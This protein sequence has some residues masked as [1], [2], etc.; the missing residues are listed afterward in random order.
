VHA[1]EPHYE[2][3]SEKSALIQRGQILLLDMWAK[4]KTENA[5]YGDITWMAYTGKASDIPGR[6]GE[7]FHIL[8]VARDK[9]ISFLRENIERQ[10]VYG[11]QVDDAC[12]AVVKDGGFGDKFTH[13]TGHSITSSVHGPGPNIDNLETED[14]RRLQ[15]GHLFSIEP[16][17]YL[18][19]CGFRTEIDV[20]ISHEGVEVTTLPLQ[21]EIRPLL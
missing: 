7:M 12:R 2:P 8:T 16:G 17:I 3:V 13:R 20:L 18:S 6:Y 21:E 5:V 19:D 4:L 1:G 14:Q 10:P 9:A 11:W 15:K